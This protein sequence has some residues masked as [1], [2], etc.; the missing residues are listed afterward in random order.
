MPLALLKDTADGPEGVG[1]KDV[2]GLP[3]LVKRRKT[4]KDDKTE[5]RT[6]GRLGWGMRS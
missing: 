1:K 5:R 3:A 6:E 2:M 4:Q